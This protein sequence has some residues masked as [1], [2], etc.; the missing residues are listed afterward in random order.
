MIC[1]EYDGLEPI[2]KSIFIGQIVH[3]IQNDSEFFNRGMELINEAAAKGI[4]DKVVFHPY[5]NQPQPE[6]E[7]ANI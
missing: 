1:K 4:F 2:E 6:H 5:I 7:A 3:A